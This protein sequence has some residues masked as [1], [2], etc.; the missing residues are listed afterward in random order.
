MVGRD[1]R[2]SL[3]RFA[4]NSDAQEGSSVVA[5]G[6]TVRKAVVLRLRLPNAGLY[7]P[8]EILA[9]GLGQIFQAESF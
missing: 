4:E 8:D 9:H 7:L 2:K 5:P 3:E 1:I 6:T